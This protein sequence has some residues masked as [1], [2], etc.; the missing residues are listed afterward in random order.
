MLRITIADDHPLFRDAIRV[1]LNDLDTPDGLEVI[2]AA[3]ASEAMHLAEVHPD[4]DLLLL[5]L[6]MPGMSGLSGLMDIRRDHPSLPVIILSASDDAKVV[7]DCLELGAMGYVPK[8]YDKA[9][10]TNAIREVLEGHI[11]QP[12][13]LAASVTPKDD[14]NVED[15]SVAQAVGRLTA[16]QTR[17]LKAITKG[18]PNKIIA[19]E[20]GIAEKTVKAHVTEIFKKLGVTNRTQA[21]LAVKHLFGT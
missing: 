7:Y 10:I 1:A 18:R 8:K 12:S 16:Q 15:Q 21:V 13:E 11:H 20:L 14:S 2:E 5:D 6:H 4:L 9:A 19:H 3:S 17:V